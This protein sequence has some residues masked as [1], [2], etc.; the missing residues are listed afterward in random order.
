MLA[1]LPS[2][3]LWELQ[4]TI[5]MTMVVTAAIVAVLLADMP[6][7]RRWRRPVLWVLFGIG[8]LTKFIV[9]P[10]FAVWLVVDDGRP[11]AKL[12]VEA[13]IH[14]RRSAHSRKQ[15]V[16]GPTP[17]PSPVGRVPRIAKLMA[18]AIRFEGL[19][20]SGAVSDY[21]ELARLGHVMC[22]RITQI[23]N[24]LLLCRTFKNSCSFCRGWSRAKIPL[25]CGDLLPIAA[26]AD[27]REQRRWDIVASRS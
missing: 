8:L 18:L 22:A 5:A 6:A 24:L 25:S 4:T 9:I 15:I 3:V 17:A 7:E 23:M 26:Q 21:A 10:L 19:I 12:T 1:F 11:R 16:A 20:R 27:W 2:L 13:T 14:F